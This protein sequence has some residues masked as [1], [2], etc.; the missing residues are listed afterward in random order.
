MIIWDSDLVYNRNSAEPLPYLDSNNDQTEKRKFTIDEV[1]DFFVE[2]MKSDSVGFIA[3]MHKAIADR[4]NEGVNHPDCIELAKIFSK[5]VDFSKTSE[6]VTIPKPIATEY[7]NLW[8]PDFMEKESRGTRESKKV[9]G[10]LYRKAKSLLMNVKHKMI[11]D[12]LNHETSAIKVDES[13]LV[14][15]YEAYLED[16]NNDYDFYRTEILEILNKYDYES[17][18]DLFAG[19]CNTTGQTFKADE[20]EIAQLAR[21]VFSKLK[22]KML[23]IFESNVGNNTQEKIK[24]AS[25]WYKVCYESADNQ[26]SRIL[27]FPW[28]VREYL[29][30]AKSKSISSRMINN[31]DYLGNN[32]LL[33]LFNANLGRLKK[34]YNSL[35]NGQQNASA[36]ISYKPFYL[37]I[38]NVVMI[39][40]VHDKSVK[41]IQKE[42]LM[43][44]IYLFLEDE[45][46]QYLLDIL[47]TNYSDDE[48]RFSNLIKRIEESLPSE[49]GL[50][51]MACK[52]YKF[53][54]SRRECGMLRNH[55]QRALSF[56]SKFA[57]ICGAEH[58]EALLD[59]VFKIWND[60]EER[61]GLSEENAAKFKNKTLRDFS[62][63]ILRKTIKN[64]LSN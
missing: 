64:N 22:K 5:A 46:S 42:E 12:T 63:N 2:F 39:I 58:F 47:E 48:K 60:P 29:A 56:V 34:F 33:K 50:F 27:S 57:H 53:Q 55:F 51:Q 3:N 9:I 59:M 14:D 8:Y 30:K 16:A 23:S 24:K 49:G 45:Y 38:T 62:I 6:K 20:Y 61:F 43:S 28:L 54:I 19:K 15:G 1:K 10:K 36:L 26:K 35:S 17:E 52:F 13:L 7:R 21:S 40:F 11:Y 37:A 25:A 31:S 41:E 32:L 4:A 18:V 44:S